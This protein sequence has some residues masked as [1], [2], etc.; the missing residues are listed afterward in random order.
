MIDLHIASPVPQLILDGVLRGTII[1]LVA[2]S[3]SLLFGVLGVPDFSQASI[4]MVGGFTTFLLVTSGDI[5]I[6]VAVPIAIVLAVGTGVIEDRVIFSRFK[7]RDQSTLLVAALAMFIIYQ[8]AAVLMFTGE[9]K[10]IPIPDVLNETILIAGAATTVLRLV[11]IAVTG[12]IVV[13]L[14]LFIT[15]TEKGTAIRAVEQNTEV[16]Y[17][18]G[19]DVDRIRALT[20]GIASGLSAVAGGLTGAI[21]SVNPFIGESEILLAFVIIIL[22]GAGNLIGAVIGGYAIGLLES[23][24]NFYITNR[25]TTAIIFT[26]VI[27]VLAFKPEGLLGEN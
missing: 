5:P 25:Y 4:V 2:L 13:G 3:L 9:S 27:V 15:R 17:L 21:F 23:F 26:I 8:N 1:V 6:Y 20:F 24:T 12:V 11:T 14:Y 7:D 10:G 22:G 16:A 18:M 19:I